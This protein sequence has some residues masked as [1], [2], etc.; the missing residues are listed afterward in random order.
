MKG[1]VE[2]AHGLDNMYDGFQLHI[3]EG[4]KRNSDTSKGARPR[5]HQI[6]GYLQDDTFNM[7]NN[8]TNSFCDMY[9]ED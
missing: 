7:V 3:L 5:L 4:S 1:P 8:V 2:F 9:F 6:G